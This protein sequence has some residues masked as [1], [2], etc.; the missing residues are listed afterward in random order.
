MDYPIYIDRHYIRSDSMTGAENLLAF[1]EWLLNHTKE[2]LVS[3]F[4]LL[5]LDILNLKKLNDEHGYAAGDAA[6]RWVTITLKEEANAKVYRISGDEFVGVLV[7]GSKQDHAQLCDKPFK[8]T[9]HN[10]N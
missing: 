2:Q 5:S 10:I 9:I 4:T 6:L 8:F 7:E 1:F 3:P